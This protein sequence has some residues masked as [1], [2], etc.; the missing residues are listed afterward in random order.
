MDHESHDYKFIP[1]ND[2]VIH[3][4]AI[5][6]VDDL[7]LAHAG[8]N[9]TELYACM[10]VPMGAHLCPYDSSC[11]HGRSSPV[12]CMVSNQP[13]NSVCMMPMHANF[14]LTLT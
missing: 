4:I 2:I 14:N 11:I 9:N 6:S 8:M 13:Q 7:N 1:F 10:H 12:T 5:H 3:Y